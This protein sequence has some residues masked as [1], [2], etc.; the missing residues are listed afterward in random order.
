MVRFR[1]RKGGRAPGDGGGEVRK[2][3]GR[4]PLAQKPTTFCPGVYSILSY[5]GKR[6]SV[7]CTRYRELRLQIMVSRVRPIVAPE[8][9]EAVQRD[10]PHQAR[11][12]VPWYMSSATG[13][14]LVRY[15]P[16]QSQRGSVGSQAPVKQ[17][18]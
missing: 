11:K 13:P 6:H 8:P 1:V 10:R 17:P 7:L 5:R 12:P 4:G 9:I 2:R 18:C 3:D 15:F 16:F 14:S